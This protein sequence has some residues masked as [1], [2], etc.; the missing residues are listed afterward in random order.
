MQLEMVWEWEAEQMA[1]QEEQLAFSTHP[2][3]D[4]GDPTSTIL[5]LVILAWSAI[6]KITTVPLAKRHS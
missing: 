2:N 5:F 3:F 4:M 6:L 1:S